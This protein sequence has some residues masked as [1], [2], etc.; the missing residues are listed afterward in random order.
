MKT[1]ADI[2]NL[3]TVQPRAIVNE[4]SFL[5][6]VNDDSESIDAKNVSDVTLDEDVLVK[7]NIEQHGPLSNYTE[8]MSLQKCENCPF[9][10]NISDDLKFTRKLTRTSIGGK[11]YVT[12]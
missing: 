12:Q 7:H 1:H 3:T 8:P 9:S 4:I 6:E 10:T 11:S 5:D 2:K